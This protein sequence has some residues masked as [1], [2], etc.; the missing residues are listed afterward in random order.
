MTL[1]FMIT[2]THNL[3]EMAANV[4]KIRLS[5]PLQ[6]S[7]FQQFEEP[8]KSNKLIIIISSSLIHSNYKIC[9][10][11]YLNPGLIWRRCN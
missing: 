7:Q 10:R 5:A 4:R 3:H 6:F 2:L 8:D 9:D 1:Q 11:N